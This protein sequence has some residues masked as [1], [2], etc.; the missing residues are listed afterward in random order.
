MGDAQGQNC[1]YELICYVSR[2]ISSKLGQ[3]RFTDILI[4]LLAVLDKVQVESKL[5]L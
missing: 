5:L 2:I 3:R 1:S 4:V